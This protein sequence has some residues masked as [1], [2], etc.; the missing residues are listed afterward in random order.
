MEPL[1]IYGRS[2]LDENGNE[3]PFETT[4]LNPIE[5]FIPREIQTFEFLE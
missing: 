5:F 1:A 3:I 4:S 2:L